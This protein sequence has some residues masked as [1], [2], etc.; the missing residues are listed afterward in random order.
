MNC[1]S[2]KKTTRLPTFSRLRLVNKDRKH[3]EKTEWK[4]SGGVLRALMCFALG[5][6]GEEAMQIK[7][8]WDPCVKL[9]ENSRSPTQQALESTAASLLNSFT[10][11]CR[12]ALNI[13]FVKY[14]WHRAC[15][16]FSCARCDLI[17]SAPAALC[18]H[19]VYCNGR[20]QRLKRAIYQSFSS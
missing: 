7:A 9:A 13:A 3:D 18:W 14:R 6:S 4:G 5:G 11:P 12:T 15:M 1:I 10:Q 8:T 16:L 20:E 17:I 2:F 19:T